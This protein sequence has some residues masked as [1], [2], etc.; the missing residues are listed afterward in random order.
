MFFI[1]LSHSFSYRHQWRDSFLTDSLYD[2]VLSCF[3]MQISRVKGGI[4]GTNEN[5]G[6]GDGKLLHAV[7]FL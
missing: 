7:L 1:Y 4:M 3:Q 2:V 5:D 6:I